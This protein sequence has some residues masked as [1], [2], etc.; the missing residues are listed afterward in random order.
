M[1]ISR[2]AGRLGA[3]DLTARVDQESA[4][5][6]PATC[7]LGGGMATAYHRRP[8]PAALDIATVAHCKIGNGSAWQGYYM[9]AGGTNPPGEHGTQESH[10]TDYPNDMPPLGYDFHAPVGEAGA[11]AASH[12]ELRRQHAFLAAFGPQLAEM[13]S[14]LPDVLPADVHDSTTLRWA[15]RADGRSGFLFLTWHQPHIP[16]P[17]YRGARFQVTLE[18]ERLLLPSRPVDIPAGTL[19]RWPIAMEVGDVRIDWATASALTVLPGEVP[20]LVLCAEPGIPVEVAVPAGVLVD[21]HPDPADPQSGRVVHTVEPGPA[22]VRLLSG[23]RPLDLLVLP[24]ADASAVWVAESAAG[25]PSDRRLLLS[26]DE[27]GWGADGR[28]VARSTGSAPVA[29]RVYDPAL[30]AFRPLPLQGHGPGAAV[31]EASVTRLRPA[32]VAVPA[33]HGLR[34]RRQSAPSAATF[35]ELAAVH[36]LR[37]PAWAGRPEQDALLRIEWAGDVAQLRIDGRPVTDR[38]WDGSPWL[39]SLRDTGCT[40]DSQVTLHVLPLSARSCVH[41]PA[42]AAERLADSAAQGRPASG[43][44]SSLTRSSDAADPDPADDGR[45]LAVDS[46]R[47]EGRRTWRERLPA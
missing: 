12:A 40:P 6:P 14:S 45:L 22:P 27:L 28:V 20:T 35:D 4:L 41:L 3:G 44:T 32:T 13:P 18:N 36:R 5:F 19:A 1:I 47:V 33:V 37:L 25:T 34:D 38:F 29:V 21:G 8:R 31:A 9:Y 43:G 46:V 23:T 17:T 39:V 15:L 11:L 26:E 42:D 10:A 30:R 2:V 16:L 7:E 24:A